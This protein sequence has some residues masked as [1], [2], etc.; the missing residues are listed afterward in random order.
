M[1]RNIASFSDLLASAPTGT[2]YFYLTTLDPTAADAERNPL[3]SFTLSEAPLGTCGTID[4]ENPLCAKLT[5]TGRLEKVTNSTEKSLALQG[6][7]E[8]HA[9]MEQWPADHGFAVYALRVSN[10]FLIDFFGGPKPLTV[11]EYFSVVPPFD[12]DPKQFVRSK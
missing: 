9:E 11:E 7:F 4:P 3:C 1:C 5:L 8:T 6:L 10:I 2:P 12:G